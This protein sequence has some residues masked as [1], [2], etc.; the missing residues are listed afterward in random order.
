MPDEKEK[1]SLEK[2]RSERDKEQGPWWRNLSPLVLGG[3]ALVGFYLLK[4]ISEDSQNKNSLLLWIAAIVVILYILSQTAKKPEDTLVSPKEAELLV[5][6]ECE[7][8]KR[9]NQFDPMSTYKVGPVSY[10]QR[11]DGGGMYYDVEV[12]VTDPYDRPR[13]FNATVMAK[14]LER[15]FT[16]LQESIGSLTGRDKEAERT[17]IPQWMMD[18]KK[19]PMLEKVLFK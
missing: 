1:E 12:K 14:G 15:G 2:I 8:K 7:R 16:T 17:I 5:E 13:F 4:K 9:W 18:M 10:L 3:A 11:R 6:R 19:H